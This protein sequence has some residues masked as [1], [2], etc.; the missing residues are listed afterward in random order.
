M[1][2]F[3]L[4]CNEFDFPEEM[5]TIISYLSLKGY[6]KQERGLQRNYMKSFLKRDG[7][8][9]KYWTKKH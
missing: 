9:G 3:E 8:D 5:K 2:A 1:K 4:R 7:A 6:I